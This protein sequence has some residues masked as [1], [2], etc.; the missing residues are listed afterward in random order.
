MAARAY[1]SGD[2]HPL[3]LSLLP[4]SPSP[5]PRALAGDSDKTIHPVVVELFTSQGCSDCPPA[6]RLLAE[7]AQRR[8]VIALTLPITY[9]DML[10]WK[11]TFATDDKHATPKVLCPRHEP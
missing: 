4:P 9:W 5:P 6:D 3:L 11:D 1:C 8:D 2:A 10:G 7:I